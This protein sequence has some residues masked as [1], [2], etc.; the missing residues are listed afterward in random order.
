MD[1]TIPSNTR[2]DASTALILARSCLALD[3]VVLA[4]NQAQVTW[5]ETQRSLAEQVVQ[6]IADDPVYRLPPVVREALGAEF[7]VGTLT[8]AAIRL[9]L[10]VRGE[11]DKTTPVEGFPDDLSS[12]LLAAGAHE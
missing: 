6:I 11:D 8:S 3:A 10:M 9:G 1:S 7:Y 2:G 4:G 5:S 12:R